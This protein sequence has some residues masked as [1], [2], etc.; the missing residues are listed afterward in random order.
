M[1]GTRSIL[2]DGQRVVRPGLASISIGAPLL[3]E[4]TSWQAAVQL[5]DRARAEILRGCGEP[6]LFETQD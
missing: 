2:R 5:R 6:D 4:T 3:V 1:R